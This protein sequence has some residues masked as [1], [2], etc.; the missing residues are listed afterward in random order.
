VVSSYDPKSTCRS[1]H[2]VGTLQLEARATLA[3]RVRSLSAPVSEEVTEQFL[4]RHPEW[5]I[6]YAGRAR[7]R[8]L[9]DAKYHITFLAAAIESDS[10]RAFLDYA[11]WA[12]RVLSSRGI[13]HAFLAENLLQVRD[14]LAAHLTNGSNIIKEYVDGAVA[15]LNGNAAE[16]TTSADA[17]PFALT[18]SMY[19]QAVL[20]GQRAAAL[21][22]AREALRDGVSVEDFYI[23]VL[24][25]TLYEV[26]R[27]WESNTITVAHEHAATAITQFV[28]AQL[29]EHIDRS[30]S[31][32]GRTLL[33][34]G[35]E[36]ELHTVGA[37]MVSDMLE[38]RGWTVHYL[39]TNLPHAAIVQ[40]IRERDPEWIGISATMLFSVPAVRRL[41]DS[42]RSEW[43]T[44]KRIV[45]GGA[46]FRAAPDLWRE[47]GVDGQARDLREAL[48]LV[49]A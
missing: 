13:G 2:G 25:A 23:H 46:A 11:R 27:L 19:L 10:P 5:V 28:M 9:E 35:L 49:S 45:L 17:D 22:V 1:F 14:A 7:E 34:T 18:R 40:A 47:I 48:A 30:A 39:G 42:I 38:A 32:N 29:Y 36:G 37:L 3:E 26:G 16:A 4:Q 6:R 20:A 21:N 43:G 15:V 8:G 44:A 31:P 41:V 33:M 24:Q 12:G